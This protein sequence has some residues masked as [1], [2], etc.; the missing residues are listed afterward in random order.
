[1]TD[2]YMVGQKKNIQNSFVFCVCCPRQGNL[3]DARDGDGGWGHFKDKSKHIFL[4]IYF[5]L[6][7]LFCIFCILCILYIY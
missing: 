5:I 2:K 6:C 7:Y 1:M 4:Q 3:T